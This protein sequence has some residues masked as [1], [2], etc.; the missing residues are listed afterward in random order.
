LNQSGEPAGEVSCDDGVILEVSFYLRERLP[1]LNLALRLRSSNG[2]L[3]L[4]SQVNE[5]IEDFASRLKPGFTTVRLAIPERLLAPDLY[6]VD[7]RAKSQRAELADHESVC[8]FR[9]IDLSTKRSERRPGVIGL[10]LPWEIVS[11]DGGVVH[12][13]LAVAVNE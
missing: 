4:Y 9:I 3:V 2:V 7:L 13:H 6:Q 10:V 5:A 11:P 12:P 8:G 1:K